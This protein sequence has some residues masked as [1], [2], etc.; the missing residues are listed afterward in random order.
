MRG[1]VVFCLE[2]ADNGKHLSELIIESIESQCEDSV[3]LKG[4]REYTA[5]NM[6]LYSTMPPQIE[7]TSIKAIP[8]FRWGNA[9]EGEMRVWVRK[10]SPF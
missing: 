2:E 10:A 1:P 3:I 7:K 4:Y 6:A 5:D 8:Y 9:G